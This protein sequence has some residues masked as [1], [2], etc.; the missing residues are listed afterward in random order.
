VQQNQCGNTGNPTLKLSDL[1]NNTGETNL[2]TI[3]PINTPRP[4]MVHQLPSMQRADI[5]KQEPSSCSACSGN[6]S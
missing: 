3:T 4:S 6:A 2:F 1:H 5:Y